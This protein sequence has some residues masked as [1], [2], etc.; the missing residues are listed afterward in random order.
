MPKIDKKIFKIKDD[1]CKNMAYCYLHQSCNKY[2]IW[3]DVNNYH[4]ILYTLSLYTYS[5]IEGNS[6][7]NVNSKYEVNSKYNVNSKYEVNSKY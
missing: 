6:K 2:K 1:C 5:N 4:I 7:Y 3:L